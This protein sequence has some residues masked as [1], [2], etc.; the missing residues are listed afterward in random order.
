MDP[1]I[2]KVLTE[3][4]EVSADEITLDKHI[5]NDL[6]ADSLTTVEIV[7]ALEEEFDM[8]MTDEDTDEM[9]TVQDIVNYIE[10]L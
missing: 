8:Q 2:I 10:S 1:R 9:F 3:H 5:M 6:G 7:M 4:L